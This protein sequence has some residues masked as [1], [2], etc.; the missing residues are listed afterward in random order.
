MLSKGASQAAAIAKDVS[1]QAT[2]KA[3][4]L[5]VSTLSF[6]FDFCFDSFSFVDFV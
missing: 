1:I 2:Q 6:F 3:S 5:S 4:E